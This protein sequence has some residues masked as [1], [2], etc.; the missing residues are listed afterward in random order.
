MQSFFTRFIPVVFILVFC[1]FF[2]FTACEGPEGPAG[3]DGTDGTH[4]SDGTD[5][6]EAA[7]LTCHN[8]DVI[9]EKR[10]ELN[11]HDHATMANSL[12]RGGLCIDNN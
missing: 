3:V 2:L 1:S 7:C 6:T 10:Y 5:I 8:N 12:S 4:G 9:F 11:M